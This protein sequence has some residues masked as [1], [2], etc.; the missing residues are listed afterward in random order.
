MHRLEHYA[1]EYEAAERT[2]KRWCKDGKTAGDPCPLDDPEQ[3]LAWWSRNKRQVAPAGIN[4]AVVRARK[5]APAAPKPVVPV[6]PEG[7]LPLLP[8]GPVAEVPEE[9]DFVIPEGRGLIAALERLEKLEAVLSVKAHQPGQ[10]TSYV[11]VVSRM[12]TTS[13]KLRK[14]AQEQGKL[15]PRAQVEE[16]LHAFHGPIESGVRGLVAT[17]ADVWGLELTPERDEAWNLACDE[18]FRKFKEEVLR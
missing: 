16:V 14:E 7:E 15:L 17:M 6:I 5:S 1:V 18:L 11:N 2:V 13:E 8:P 4:A 10:A 12:T 9:D 3:L